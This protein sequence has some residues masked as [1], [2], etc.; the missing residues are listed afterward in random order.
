MQRR[1]YTEGTVTGPK[2]PVLAP[3]FAFVRNAAIAGWWTLLV[4]LPAGPARSQEE[5]PP[6]TATIT[7]G[8]DPSQAERRTDTW[9]PLSVL[10]ENEGDPIQGQIVA[11]VFYGQIP[12]DIFYCCPVDLPTGSRKMYRMALY[13]PGSTAEVQVCLVDGKKQTVLGTLAAPTL[14]YGV[15]VVAALARDRDSL[16]FMQGVPEGSDE[17]EYR[18]ILYTDVQ[19]LPTDWISYQ[20]L[21]TLI[22]SGGQS[23]IRLLPEQMSAFRRWLT[24][25]GRLVMFVG[26]QRQ[27]LTGTLWEQFTP[28]KLTATQTLPNGTA[29]EGPIFREQQTLRGPLVVSVGELHKSLHP[30]VLLRAGEIPLVVEVDWGAG[31][32][33]YCAFEPRPNMLTSPEATLD[34][35]DSLLVNSGTLPASVTPQLDEPVSEFLRSLLQVELPSAWFIAGFLGL[36][37]LL[38][39]PVNYF[40][41]RRFRRL[42]WAWLLVPVWAIVFAFAAYHIGA[43]YQRGT[44]SFSEISFIEA[45]P[46]STHGRT[47]SYL[48]IYSPIRHWYTVTFPGVDTF[49][50]VVKLGES[51]TS[52][53]STSPGESLSARYEPE[54]SKISDVLIHHWS[55]RMVKACHSV[56]LQGGVEM[57][58]RWNERSELVGEITNKTPYTI[59]EPR[60]Y[61]LDRYYRLAE[62][63]EPDSSCPIP[64]NYEPIEAHLGQSRPQPWM[65][66]RRRPGGMIAPVSVSGEVTDWYWETMRYD[67]IGRGLSLFTGRIGHLFLEPELDRPIDKREGQAILAIVFDP[68]RWSSG[69][70]QIRPESWHS[71]IVYTEG[72]SSPV[73]RDSGMITIERGESVECGLVTRFN[74]RKSQIRRLQIG[75]G[76]PNSMFR[77]GINSGGGGYGFRG[78]R[79]DARISLDLFNYKQANIYIKNRRTDE[80][81]PIRWKPDARGMLQPLDMPEP[82][83]YLQRRPGR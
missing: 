76:G 56:D 65:F 53:F 17:V 73:D 82:Q 71:E 79:P 8:F 70:F 16:K 81:E 36:Y 27:E 6:L 11:Q 18:R 24:M 3:V 39:V 9:T 37:I 20:S 49:P 63:L 32:V 28:L 19:T 72:F 64:E 43:I 40:V 38:V 33:V 44:V 50:Q 74:L 14:E 47:A 23:E 25:G 12:T 67:S 34:L 61:A 5:P 54:A 69:V 78:A 59:L 22:W 77:G 45:L 57:D 66:S 29:L 10:I 26:A 48:S 21:D 62:R 1:D 60:L 51:F 83:R 68:Y 75:L 2:R 52:R 15:D 42:E 7:L 35:W 80:W 31:V 58:L 46:R 13:L 55:Q 41:F 4:L 30:R